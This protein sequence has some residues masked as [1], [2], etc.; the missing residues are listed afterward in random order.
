L[1]VFRRSR[2]WCAAAGVFVLSDREGGGGCECCGCPLSLETSDGM[3]GGC[4]VCH[5]WLAGKP[6]NSFRAREVVVVVANPLRHSNREWRGGCWQGN[7]PTRIASEQ[8]VVVMGTNPLR[9]SNREWEAV[10]W[11][12]NPPTGVSSEGGVGG[13]RESPPSLESRVRIANLMY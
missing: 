12:K 7:P 10:S 2:W 6:S 5:L 11:Q 13:G 8:G 4:D 3:G 1:A 9:H